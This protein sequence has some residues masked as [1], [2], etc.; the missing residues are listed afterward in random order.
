VL[1]IRKKNRTIGTIGGQ[2]YLVKA[3]RA[4]ARSWYQMFLLGVRCPNLFFCGRLNRAIAEQDFQSCFVALPV[5]FSEHTY[6][7]FFIR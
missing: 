7:W 6:G 3:I 1:L 4:A 2:T 5:L